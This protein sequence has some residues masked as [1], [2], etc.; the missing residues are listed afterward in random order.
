M[1]ADKPLGGR[2]PPLQK[3]TGGSR[4]R[5]APLCSLP[6]PVTIC[7]NYLPLRMASFAAFSDAELD[8]LL[9]GTWIVWPVLGPNRMIMS[10]PAESFNSS[11]RAGNHERVLRLTIRK[12]NNTPPSLCA[13]CFFECDLSAM[14]ATTCDFVILFPAIILPPCGVKGSGAENYQSTR[15]LA[16]IDF[17]G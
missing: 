12:L 9:R 2:R 7:A 1:S 11:L 4:Y 13:A 14:W 8:D 10:V 5:A 3:P 16:T 6:N 15:R 17:T